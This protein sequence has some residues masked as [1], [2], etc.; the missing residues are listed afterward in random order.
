MAS[1]PY[2]DVDSSLRALAGRAEGFG[3]FAVGGL[4]G[5]LYSVTTLAGSFFF[6]P[7]SRFMIICASFV[8]CQSCIFL[9]MGLD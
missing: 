7:F 3:R 9:V 6:P 5:P 4:H 2:A 1:L 8:K